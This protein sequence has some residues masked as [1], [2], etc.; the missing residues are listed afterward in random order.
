VAAL[1]WYI[2]SDH[3]VFLPNAARD[4]DELVAV[5]GENAE[6]DTSGIYMVDIRVRK[7]SL[8]ERLVP[9]ARDDGASLV[10]E[11]R[12]NP[13]GVSEQER[14]EQSL[15]E[16]SRSQQIAVAV[17]LRE[18]GYEVDVRPIGAEVVLVLPGSP[19]DGEL[20][21][22]DVIVSVRGTPVQTPEEVADAMEDVRP[23]QSVVWEIRRDGRTREITLETRAAEDDPGRAVVGVQI[24]EAAEID[25]PLEIR[26]DAGDVGG[27]SAGLAFAL[28][29]VDELGR[30]VDRGRRIAVTGALDLRG[31]VEAIGGV[32]QKAFG[33]RLVD[34]DVFVVPEDNAAEARRYAG[35]L[36]VVAVSTF[37]ETL[38]ALAT[39]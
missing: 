7:A 8:L 6:D 22:G 1:L 10:P 31:N 13:V 2:P 32:K 25:F 37:S 19:A 4:V 26:I 21:V 18:L 23:G 17:A 27:P 5:P 24:E 39:M 12:V 20:D 11:E 9:A 38:T 35:D 15:N 36:R 30:E 33:A 28:D 29:V 16:M 14:R 34:A 3:Y